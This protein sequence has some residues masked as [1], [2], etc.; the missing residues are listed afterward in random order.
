MSYAPAGEWLSTW[1]CEH[2]VRSLN[3]RGSPHGLRGVQGWEGG[4]GLEEM[5]RLHEEAAM[6][7]TEFLG[8]GRSLMGRDE[9]R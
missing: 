9:R 1:L 2:D 8:R 3:L 4:N 6:V 7:L 5:G